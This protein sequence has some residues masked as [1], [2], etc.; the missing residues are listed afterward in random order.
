MVVSDFQ[1]LSVIIIILRRSL[2]ILV[3]AGI[4]IGQASVEDPDFSQFVNPFIGT[5]AYGNTFPGAALPFGMIQWSPDTT[6]NG[7]YKYRDSTI[8]GFSLTHLSG[9]GCPIFGDIPFLPVRGRVANS[10]ATNPTE[11]AQRFSHSNE[12]AAPGYYQVDL[13]SGVQVK[14]VVTARTGLGAFT[15]PPT[16]EANLLINAGGS[17]AGKSIASVQ[18]VD[19]R[20][21]TGSATS[22]AFCGSNTVYTIYFAVEFDRPFQSFGTWNAGAVNLGLRSSTGKQPGAFLTFDTTR[23]PA[24]KAKV[25]ISFVSRENALLNLRTE[26]SDWDIEALRRKARDTWNGRLSQITIGGVTVE[27]K[28]IFYTALYHSWLSPNTFS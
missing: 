9:A 25:G 18:V 6:T 14:L 1:L 20:R 28:E 21:V 11:Y 23:T 15:F 12:K 19:D 17:A 3:L 22:G 26:N 27:E 5:E 24:V 8:R 10:P 7:F 16:K 4:V 2:M 13:D